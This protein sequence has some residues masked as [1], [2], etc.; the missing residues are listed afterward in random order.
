MTLQEL[1]EDPVAVRLGE[2]IYQTVCFSCH[3]HRL[4]GGTGFDL[5]DGEWIHGSEPS[6]ILKRIAKG[7]PEKGMVAFEAVYNESTLANV[8]AFLLSE[9]VGFRELQH[10]VFPAP[11][12]ASSW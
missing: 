5:R 10:Q 4:E 12:E 2:E 8:V 9:R 7:F 6:S 11:A 3:G 1:S